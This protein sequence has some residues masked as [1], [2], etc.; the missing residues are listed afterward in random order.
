[1]SDKKTDNQRVIK[2]CR[3]RHCGT[4]GKFIIERLEA[5][6]DKNPAKKI[7]IE[8]CPCRGMCSDGPIMVE[9]SNGKTVIHKRMNPIKAAKIL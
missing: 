4:V 3:G 7:K 2:V 6:I 9:E 1:M 5:E 8:P